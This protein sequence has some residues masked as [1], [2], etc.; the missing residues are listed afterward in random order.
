MMRVRDFLKKRWVK[1]ILVA[2]GVAVLAALLWNRYQ[3]ATTSSFYGALT[4]AQRDCIVSKTSQQFLDR[5]KVRGEHF[6]DSDQSM[7]RA[8][9]G[10]ISGQFYQ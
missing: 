2:F 8:M 1:A 10:C 5:L 7:I 6:T 9:T 4:V 3:D